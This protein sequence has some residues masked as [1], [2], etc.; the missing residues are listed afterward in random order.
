MRGPGPV[1]ITATSEGKVGSVTGVADAPPSANLLYQRTTPL[2]NEIYTLSLTSGGV[3]V[4]INAGNVS[5][6]PSVSA[7]GS[8]IAFFVSMTSLNA[9]I[10]EDIFAVDRN[11]MNMKRLTQL[12]GVDNAPAWSPVAGHNVIAFQ[13][14]DPATGRS[15]IWIM[16]GNGANQR[17]LTADLPLGQSR[18]EPA[19]S[20]DGEWIAFTSSPWHRRTGPRLDLDHALGWQRAA[21]AHGESGQRVRPEPELVAGR[22]AHRVPARRHLDRDGRDGRRDEPGSRWH[23]DPAVVVAGWTSHCLRVAAVGARPGR[24]AAVHGEAGRHEQASAD[25]ERAVGRRCVADLVS[26]LGC[27]H[28]EIERASTNGGSE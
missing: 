4:K 28:R 20:P 18:G 25:D 10:V 16:D 12:P 5:H 9:E 24:L 22:T 27:G 19:W 21:G 3:P 1:T 11:G 7:D 13:R 2:A 26:T 23:V 17:N 14:L 15:D 6:Q 8:R